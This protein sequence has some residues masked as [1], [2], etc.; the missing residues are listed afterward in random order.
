MH[1]KIYAFEVS[2][3]PNIT[4]SVQIRQL[5]LV[6]LFGTNRMSVRENFHGIG[7]GL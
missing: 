1:A 3:T 6:N 5:T 2:K 7:K 4:I